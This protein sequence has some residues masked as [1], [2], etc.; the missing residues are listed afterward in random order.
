L[1]VERTSIA[2]VLLLTPELYGDARGWLFESYSRKEFARA[3]GAEVEFVQDNHSRSAK[4]VLRGL[5]YQLTRPQGKLV[6]VVAGEIWDV[7][8]DLRRGSPSFGRWAGLKLD[9]AS[10]RMLWVPPGFAHGFIALSDAVE[11]LYKCSDYYVPED[12]RT[13]LW[14]DPALAIAWPLA[15]EPLVS[16]RDR[17]GLPLA[18][19]DT[20][21]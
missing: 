3:A 9:A 19:A 1:K 8:V 20:Y 16:E 5:H 6:R 13:L 21:P 15:G 7:A 14:N 12:E 4:G 11:V 10:R 18:S 17:L 2:E